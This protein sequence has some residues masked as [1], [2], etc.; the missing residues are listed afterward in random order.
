MCRFATQGLSLLVR[1]RSTLL[2][3]LVFYAAVFYVVLMG[4]RTSYMATTE[5]VMIVVGLK[6]AFLRLGVH[7]EK[8]P[9]ARLAAS[10]GITFLGLVPTAVMGIFGRWAK[11]QI[12]A[13]AMG[14]FTA[15]LTISVLRKHQTTEDDARTRY[16]FLCLYLIEL[17]AMFLA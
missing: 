5:R 14:M 7:W 16:F 2:D 15:A 4:S 17:T 3:L 12:T 13:L 9:L 1:K 10:S 11:R 6:M 8:I